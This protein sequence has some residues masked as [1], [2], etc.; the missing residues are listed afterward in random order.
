MRLIDEKW[1]QIFDRYDVAKEIERNGLFHI[2]ANQIKEFKEPR[3]MTKF[4]T[5]E[6]L[7]R[8]FGDKLGILPVT[9]GSYVIGEFDLYEDFPEIK[10][11]T[12]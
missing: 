8:V 4:D 7:P 9:R 1:E 10:D 2:T 6:S 5:R 3:L 11:N 12:L